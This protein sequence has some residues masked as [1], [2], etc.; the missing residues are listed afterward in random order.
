MLQQKL[1][2]LKDGLN[3]FKNK[4]IVCARTK[5]F[6]KR[7]TRRPR[8]WQ[9]LSEI[10]KKFRVCRRIDTFLD[11]C[12]GPGEFAN[13]TMSLNPFCNAYGVT[14]TDNFVCAYKKELI[15]RKNFTPIVGP[16]VSGNVFDKNVVFEVSVKCGN[17]CDLVLADGSIDVNK[18]ENEQE[19]LNYDLIRCETQIILICL[20]PGGNSVL[21]VFDAFERET[22]QMLNKFINHFEKWVLYKPPSSRPANSERYLICLNKLIV[23]KSVDYTNELKRRFRKFYYIQLKSLN[24][25]VNL[26]EV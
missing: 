21:K 20:R 22:L 19:R 7:R 6:D 2:E 26:L 1:N 4:S 9:K 18:R 13:Y 23:P 16:D 5:L 24:A 3:T 15:K 25:L 8:C 17:V 10:D 12:G 11:L 14:L